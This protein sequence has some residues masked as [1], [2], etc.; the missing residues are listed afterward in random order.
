MASCH[1]AVYFST[2]RPYDSSAQ[3]IGLELALCLEPDT[4]FASI[5]RRPTFRMTS[6][7]R[8]DNLPRTEETKRDLRAAPMRVKESLSSVH[9]SLL[10]KHV[11]YAVLTEI[12][13]EF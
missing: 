9:A 7:Q 2:S 1:L 10:A 5:T 11:S 6:A 8:S 12:A 3:V 13:E 4:E